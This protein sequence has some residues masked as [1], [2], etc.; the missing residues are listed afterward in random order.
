MVQ[1][2]AKPLAGT[3]EKQNIGDHGRT[4]DVL[5]IRQAIL[6]IIPKLNKDEELM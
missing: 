4:E 6:K 2:W 3:A 5:K 1:L